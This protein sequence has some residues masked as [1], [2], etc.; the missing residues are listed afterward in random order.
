MSVLKQQ[1]RVTLTTDIL[2][3]P[4]L[5]RLTDCAECALES[6][7][8]HDRRQKKMATEK[9]ESE[10]F[11]RQFNE[12]NNTTV[13]IID[14]N[15]LR[16]KG[17]LM[18]KFFINPGDS[19]DRSYG[20]VKRPKGN[21]TPAQRPP[22]PMSQITHFFGEPTVCARVTERVET[23]ALGTRAPVPSRQITEFFR[24]PNIEI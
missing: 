17:V 21:D 1:K 10:E 14:E 6:R 18:K 16:R 3:L 4:S 11:S 13:V 7:Q 15:T 12:R 8:E 23:S 24:E 19:I 9:Q 20:W 22:A 2:Q 5:L